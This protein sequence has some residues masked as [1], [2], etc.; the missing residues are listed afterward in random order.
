MSDK[1]TT[2]T[3]TSGAPLPCR[4]IVDPPADGPLQMAVDE[5][6]LESPMDAPAAKRRWLRWSLRTMFVVVTVAGCLVGW[7]TY[8]LNW[9]RQR[10][11]VVSRPNV[12]KLDDG[13]TPAPFALRM[14]GESGQWAIAISFFDDKRAVDVTSRVKGTWR[15]LKNA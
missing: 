9:I 2:G 8:N 14:L 6:L 3:H 11:E 13:N 15:R 4:V 12:S 10:H 1:P 7:L 5:V